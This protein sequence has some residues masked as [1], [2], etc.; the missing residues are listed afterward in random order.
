MSES[1]SGC[2]GSTRPP[3]RKPRWRRWSRASASR[4][5]R[6]APL[7]VEVEWLVH[8]LRAPQLPVPPE[9]LAAAVCRAA[10]RAPEVGADRRTRR[11]AGTQLAA[12]RLPDGVRRHR[13]RRPDRRP[14]R[15]GRAA[16]LGLGGTARIPGTPP[17][18][19][20]PNLA[21]TP[22]RRPRPRR[23]PA[24]RA[25]MCTSA[26]VQVC[27]DAGHEEPGPA[28]ARPPLVAGPP[29][30][31]G[32]GGRVRQL[33]DGRG[34]PTGWR[35]TRQ[36]LW[37]AMDAGPRR[38]PRR[39]AGTRAPPGPRHVLDAPVMCVRSARAAPGTC[40]RA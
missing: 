38:A 27:L 2:A 33:P 20:A 1:I 3:S 18:A 39:W 26:S 11:P 12:R 34:R 23:G 9:R 24:G 35:S 37:T 10:C 30:G 31:R 29:A 36:S 8:E 19:P 32:A 7:G 21:T 15:P 6:P 5:A 25:M 40:P 22:W 16:G 17:R 28:R 14:H 13:L 4:P